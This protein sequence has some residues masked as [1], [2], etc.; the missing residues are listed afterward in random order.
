MK[1]FDQ[2][3]QLFV[4]TRL[5]FEIHENKKKIFMTF[6]FNLIETEKNMF[7]MLHSIGCFKILLKV[8][9]EESIVNAPPIT[10]QLFI[11][12]LTFCVVCFLT[13]PTDEWCVHNRL[14]NANFVDKFK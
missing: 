4:L 3:P 11:S 8:G 10:D 13:L 6:Q 9:V 5:T 2:Y 1:G 14:F 7:C 12:N